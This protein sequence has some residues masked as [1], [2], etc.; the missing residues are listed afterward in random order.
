MDF[1]FDPLINI[2]VKTSEGEI[3]LSEYLANLD[4]EGKTTVLMSLAVM[5]QIADRIGKL[6]SELLGKGGAWA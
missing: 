4:E 1:N 3:D 5:H 6:S 2:P